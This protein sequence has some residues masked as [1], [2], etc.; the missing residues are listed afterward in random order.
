MKDTTIKPP[1]PMVRLR[2]TNANFNPMLERGC[3]VKPIE[4]G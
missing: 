3:L 2:E 4:S 1:L